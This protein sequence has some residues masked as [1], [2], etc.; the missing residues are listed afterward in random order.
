M[1]RDN[2]PI[3]KE[4]IDIITAIRD[5]LIEIK[6]SA[7]TEDNI[8]FKFLNQYIKD[9]EI[10]GLGEATHGTKEFQDM[11]TIIISHLVENLGFRTIILEESYCHSLR[12]N[13]YI[14]NGEGTAEEAVNEGLS[15]AWVF[16]TEETLALVKWMR[17]YNLRTDENNKVRFYGM[18]VQGA[19]KALEIIACYIRKVDLKNCCMVKEYL[20]LFN[21]KNNKTDLVALKE[22]LLNIE[23]F[24]INNKVHYIKNSSKREFNDVYHC[25]EVY[26]QFLEYSNERTFNARDRYMYE[27]T[28]WIIENEKTYN[29]GK[30]IV[31]GHND[32]IS[33]SISPNMGE[34]RQLGYWL[35]K[36]YKEKYYNMGFEFSRGLFHSW[37]I[38]TRELKI[39]KVDNSIKKDL[40]ARIFEETGVPTFYIDLNSSCRRSLS[41][42]NF[43]STLNRYYS[44]GALYDDKAE[45]WG[46]DE[47]ILGDMYDSI[48]YIKDST[49]TTRC[50]ALDK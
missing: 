6:A 4:N 27:N 18:D 19:E 2:N 42:N 21:E 1:N 12:M 34:D 5:N 13:S 38:S 10:I 28:K 36:Q 44:I 41:L 9:K 20:E 25:I 23:E 31:I 24:F 29:E 26:K 43:I 16:K 33:K 14:L 17:E 46:V 32:H 8:D 49:N 45:G 7:S 30:V 15:F 50:Q 37:D 3:L 48:V 22:K 39:F 11:R 40:A 35:K 47:L